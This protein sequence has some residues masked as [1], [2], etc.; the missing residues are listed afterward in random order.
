M[1]PPA[2][3]IPPQG[4][5][6]LIQARLG[7]TRLPGKVLLPLAGRPLLGWVVARARLIAPQVAVA[8][9]TGAGEENRPLVE[10]CS[11]EGVP[12][13]R[14]SEDDVLDRYCQAALA[15]EAHTVLRLTADNPMLDQDLA[16]TLLLAHLAHGADYSSAKEEFGSGLPLGVG[17]EIFSR[18]VLWD[19]NQRELSA[20]DREHV[21]EAILAAPERFR[22]LGLRLG[23]DH[24][25]CRLTVDT[26]EDL[27]R[28]GAWLASLPADQRLA[29]EAWRALAAPKEGRV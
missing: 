22:C 25:S 19:L 6:A 14:G 24:A 7:S 26:P 4:V 21:N 8:V 23:G 2:G 10:W 1:N 20:G 11:R 9:I 5:W 17:V 16:R 18:R 29:A 13:L 15:L 28:V 12:C 27:A 3:L